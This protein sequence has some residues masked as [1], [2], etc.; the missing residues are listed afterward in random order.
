MK[1]RLVLTDKSVSDIR[2]VKAW[3]EKQQKGLGKKFADTIFK[4][5]EE[6]KSAPLAYPNKYKYTREKYVRK[7]PY[8][9]IYSIEEDV[10]FILRVFAC[11]MNPGEKYKVYYE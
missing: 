11:K 3:Y 2:K 1:Y 9:V 7:F 5:V 10:I 6:I 8:L 4:N